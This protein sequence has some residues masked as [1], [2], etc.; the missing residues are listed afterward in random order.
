M[1]RDVPL[2]RDILHRALHAT[3]WLGLIA[4]TPATQQTSRERK[5]QGGG[6][7][8][9]GFERGRGPTAPG[10]VE[11]KRPSSS[12]PQSCPSAARCGQI[13]ELRSS[14]CL[15][16]IAASQCRKV[17]DSKVVNCGHWPIRESAIRRHRTRGLKSGHSA[18]KLHPS[19][20]WCHVSVSTV[21]A[22]TGASSSKLPR[23]VPAG[24]SERVSWGPL[25]F[26]IPPKYAP[27][28][29]MRA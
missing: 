24:G 23:L 3:A 11:P 6:S 27:E 2:G 17:T 19:A 22:S 25:R 10:R 16:P 26:L 14:G 18:Q 7:W 21:Q 5:Y 13:S 4:A 9:D 28:A 8:T 12:S 20:A 29:R 1:R 15:W